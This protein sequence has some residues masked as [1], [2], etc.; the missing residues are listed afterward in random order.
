MES[1]LNVMLLQQELVADLCP[2]VISDVFPYKIL[3]H[4]GWI[5]IAKRFVYLNNHKH[6]RVLDMDICFTVLC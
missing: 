1:M 5:D 6:T 3:L 4:K 2:E